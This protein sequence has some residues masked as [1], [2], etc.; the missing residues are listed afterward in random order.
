MTTTF[1]RIA[2]EALDVCNGVEMAT[3]EGAVA[4]A[5]L[6]AT[7]R[8][9]DVGTG[10]AGVAIRLNQRFGLNVTAIEFD[11]V[12]AELAKARIGAAKVEVE[13]VIGTAAQV[14]EGLEPL[15]LIVALGTTNLTG[16]GRPTPEAGFAFLRR[17]I[18]PGGW[19]LWGDLVWRGEPSIPLR[20]VVEATNLYTDDAGWVAAAQGAGFSLDWRE[21]SSQ[22]VFEAY[23]RDAVGAARDWLQTHPYAPE[24]EAVRFNADRMQAVFDFGHGLIGFGL[25]LFRAA[26]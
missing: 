12:M 10:N 25:Y 6:S 19:L 26:D 5:R 11:P 15:D 13:L 14:L 3:V 9:V 20:Q 18:R 2:Y 4:R 16:E 17:R 24:A 8:A 22:A 7:A 23:A 21:I 1:G